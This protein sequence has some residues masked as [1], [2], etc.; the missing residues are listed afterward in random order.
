MAAINSNIKLLSFLLIASLFLSACALRKKKSERAAGTLSTDLV[1]IEKA[2]NENAFDFEYLS[3]RGAGRF[4][5]LGMQQ[6]LTLNFRMKRHEIVWISV[7]AILGIEV[8]RAL[9]TKDSVY[10]IQ[11]LPERNYYEYS[12]DSLS[13]ILSV[14]LS[15]TQL[16]DL[17]IGNPL[18]P[19]SGA[20]VALQG[21]SVVV[22]KRSSDFILREFFANGIPKIARNLL[23]S[24]AKDGTADVHYLTFEEVNTKQMPSKVN[25]FV[26][27]PDFTAKLDLNYT[28]ISLEPISQFPFRKP[29]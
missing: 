28:N 19:Y 14:P 18:L 10:I 22:E 20:K 23:L 11:N 2:V 16:Q 5:G 24:T 4:E 6:N 8:A 1:A 27:R 29:H 25:I 21:D 9:V 12:L 15:V 17:F 7:Q 3:F 26:Q 13:N